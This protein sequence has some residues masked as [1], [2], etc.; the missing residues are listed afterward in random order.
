LN[1]LLLAFSAASDAR[2]LFTLAAERAAGGTAA[3]REPHAPP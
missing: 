3:R 1:P 2:A